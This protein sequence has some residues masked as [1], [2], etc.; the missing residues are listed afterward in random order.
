M[1]E[2]RKIVQLI[3]TDCRTGSRCNWFRYNPS[4]SDQHEDR[5]YTVYKEL[6]KRGYDVWVE[7]ILN[8]NCRP[9]ILTF[10]PNNGNSMIIEV[11][12]NE[13]YEEAIKKT[14]KYP[15]LEILY[16]MAE[17]PFNPDDIYI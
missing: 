10:N 15:P 14:Q 2:R 5:K 3:R 1:L 6:L 12:Y 4:Y 17:N 7:P 11:L 16:L 9:D 13:T 8:N